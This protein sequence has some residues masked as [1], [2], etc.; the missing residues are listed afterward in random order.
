MVP[1]Q[2]QEQIYSLEITD[3]METGRGLR[4]NNKAAE[5]TAEAAATPTASVFKTQGAASEHPRE[6]PREIATKRKRDGG[7][8]DPP[9]KKIREEGA[10][11]GVELASAADKTVS[12]LKNDSG[13][14][15]EAEG[16][17]GTDLMPPVIGIPRASAKPDKSMPINHQSLDMALGDAIVMAKLPFED[18]ENDLQMLSLTSDNI[19]VGCE[20][21]QE[22]PKDDDQPSNVVQVTDSQEHI[23]L[24]A[25][26]S[27]ALANRGL[28]CELE[29]VEHYKGGKAWYEKR[30]RDVE[31]G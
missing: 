27:L 6:E 17:S 28:C 16:N 25:I 30:I 15:E 7:P 26:L 12:P 3:A 10:K 22:A 24:S 9:N 21:D 8:T 31:S 14:C 18:P 4:R 23:L 1:Y 19:D 5:A 20:R 13:E 29:I 11:H 2:S